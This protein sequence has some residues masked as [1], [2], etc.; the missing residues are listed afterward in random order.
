MQRRQSYRRI[1]RRVGLFSISIR[2]AP[3]SAGQR[4]LSRAGLAPDHVSSPPALQSGA[5]G[6]DFI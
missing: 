3:R 2:V 1:R 4:R 5:G 6:D